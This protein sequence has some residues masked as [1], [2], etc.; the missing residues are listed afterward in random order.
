MPTLEDDAGS[1]FLQIHYGRRDIAQRI[2]TT[3]NSGQLAPDTVARA[4]TF[5]DQTIIG[6]HKPF[7]Y[8]G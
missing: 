6:L 7:F 4:K 5:R 1:L 3:S 2:R 8:D